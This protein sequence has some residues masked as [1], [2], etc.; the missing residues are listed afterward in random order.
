MF[1]T[2]LF[3]KKES[4][5]D[6]STFVSSLEDI[7]LRKK[8]VTPKFL[9]KLG[10]IATLYNTDN[11]RYNP[12]DTVSENIHR[13]ICFLPYIFYCSGV[14]EGKFSL[15]YIGDKVRQFD[16]VYHRNGAGVSKYHKPLAIGEKEWATINKKYGATQKVG[17]Y[18]IIGS[19]VIH[20]LTVFP[21]DNIRDILDLAFYCSVL[22]DMMANADIP[23]IGVSDYISAMHYPKTVPYI[24]LGDVPLAQKTEKI[25]SDDIEEIVDYQKYMGKDLTMVSMI[26]DG[27]NMVRGYI[28]TPGI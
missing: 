22:I 18:A 11:G 15:N 24:S 19:F 26:F 4:C 17:N 2:R 13:A 3:R 5:P 25:P 16:I 8:S 28:A 27:R 20:F 21:H 1:F 6:Y 14:P 10:A 23:G 12:A 9:E 7:I